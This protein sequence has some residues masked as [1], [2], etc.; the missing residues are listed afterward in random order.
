[1]AVAHFD[2]TC[3][4]I[5]NTLLCGAA[6]VAFGW[7]ISPWICPLTGIIS[8]VIIPKLLKKSEPASAPKPIGVVEDLTWTFHLEPGAGPHNCYKFDT[9][10][11]DEHNAALDLQYN[12]GGELFWHLTSREGNV[13]STLYYNFLKLNVHHPESAWNFHKCLAFFRNIPKERMQACFNKA[14]QLGLFFRAYDYF[15]NEQDQDSIENYLI[16]EDDKKKYALCFLQFREKYDLGWKVYDKTTGSI[17]KFRLDFE[18]DVSK[19]ECRD[20]LKNFRVR[21]VAT[22]GAVLKNVELE[23]IQLATKLKGTKWGINWRE[24]ALTLIDAG[25]SRAD[26]FTW[27]GHAELLIEG[28]KQGRYFVWMAHVKAGKDG[29]AEIIL[30]D[31]T[32][33]KI[34]YAG[35]SDT[36]IRD[37]YLVQN[38]IDRIKLEIC[39][40]NQGNPQVFFNL[41]GGDALF[42]QTATSKNFYKDREIKMADVDDWVEIAPTSPHPEK[43]KPTHNCTTYWIEKL[44]MVNVDISGNEYV[45]KYLFTAP[46]FYTSKG[47]KQLQSMEQTASKMLHKAGGVVNSILESARDSAAALLDPPIQTLRTVA[48]VTNV[49]KRIAL[50][51]LLDSDED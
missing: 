46:K 10:Q 8:M 26:P 35:K 13:N 37:S 49:A 16:F 44:K 18:K 17:T 47:G 43:Q 36:W 14:I 45:F 32:E 25:K 3:T 20:F 12:E 22:E 23:E 24:W 15:W 40:Q 42:N 7:G 41:R 6:G 34:S 27:G 28:V 48:A 51:D 21:L 29:V 2:R 11:S 31:K 33:T 4:A 5:G 9:S 30:L 19:E 1:M 50:L 39:K 38:M